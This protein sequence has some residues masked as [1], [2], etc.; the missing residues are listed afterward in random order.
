MKNSVAL[1]L[2]IL[3]VV[4]NIFGQKTEKFDI[5]SYS[6]PNGW[7]KTGNSDAAFFATEDKT[8]NVYCAITLFRAFASKGDSKTNF[9]A[10]WNSLVADSF[11][12]LNAPQMSA[13]ANENGWTIESG[14][15]TYE[16][17]GAKGMLMLI[18]I[19]GNEKMVNVLV[20][21]NTDAYQNQIS[22]FVESISLPPVAANQITELNRD[23]VQQTPPPNSFASGNTNGITKSTTTFSDGWTARVQ[24]DY[25]LV[26]KE[27]F[28]VFLCYQIQINDQMRQMGIGEYFWKNY[29]QTL[30]NA[31]PQTVK[32]DDV[33]SIDFAEGNATD[34]QSGRSVYVAM[35]VSKQDGTA[36][37]V[38]AAAPDRQTYYNQFP[39]PENLSQMLN[40]NR[41]AV[42]ADD[43]VGEWGGRNAPF[44]QLYNIYTGNSAGLNMASLSE[45]FNFNI[46]GTY[47]SEHS[48]ATGMVGS[49]RFSEVKLNGRFQVSDW[50]MIL[51]NRENGKTST[52]SAYFEVVK[53][54]KILHMTDKQYSSMQFHLFKN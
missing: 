5:V 20:L 18:T 10:A 45:H 13:P 17:N 19:S 9:N 8:K 15:S 21:T 40:S 26:T 31:A 49:Q 46:N 23:P 32:R 22:S 35:S 29:V 2:I 43:L 53:G 51:T 39:R 54:G 30:F 38:I 3:T 47:A 16:K 41:F 42:T 28:R 24:P 1:A 34:K 25:I 33:S 44:V 36:K 27:N 50:E 48:A 12:L 7:Q 11:K 6:A 52:F 4:L 14:V 37:V